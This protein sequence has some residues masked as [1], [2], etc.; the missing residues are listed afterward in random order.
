MHRP[1]SSDSFF[2]NT[3]YL[4]NLFQQYQKNPES[5]DSSWNM[6]FKGVEFAS[7]KSAGLP[8][9]ARSENLSFYKLV[10]DM[11]TQ[12]CFHAHLDPLTHTKTQASFTSESFL[13]PYKLTPTHLTNKLHPHLVEILG[14]GRL[15]AN[16]GA[17]GKPNVQAFTWKDALKALE[18]SYGGALS[19][20]AQACSPEKRDWLY[21]EFE[22]IGG[23]CELSIASEQKKQLFSSLVEAE[24]LEAFLHSRFVGTKRFSIEG[25][26]ALI[27]ML[28]YLGSMGTK[29]GVKE[30]VMGMAHRGRLNVLSNF[31]KQDMASF[32]TEL[33]AGSPVFSLLD[34]EGDLKYHNGYSSVRDFAG[35]QLKMFLAYNPSHLESVNAVVQ[36]MTRAR[37]QS[38]PGDKKSVL[39]L[40]CH[41]DAA[42]SG[43]GVVSEA[44]QLSKLEGYAVGGLLHVVLNN[45]IGFTTEPKDAR[46]SAF[47]SDMGKVIGAPSLLVNADNI[48]ACLSAMDIAFRYRQHFGEDVIIDLIGYRRYGHNEGDEPSFTQARMY[49]QIKKHKRVLTQ[50]EEELIDQSILKE[51]ERQSLMDQKM[52]ELQKHLDR[53]RDLISQS[54][55][56]PSSQKKLKE[57]PHEAI[58]KTKGALWPSTVWDS[59]P[60]VQKKVDTCP[61]DRDFNRV[62]DC[63]TQVPSLQ[64]HPKVKKLISMRERMS[65]KDRIDWATAELLAYGTLVLENHRVR[66]SGQDTK[67]GTFS[68]RHS[69]YWDTENSKEYS[70][71]LE[72]SVQQKKGHFEVTNS[73]LSEMAAMAFE[74]GF[75]VMNPNSLVL[76]EAQFGD[77]VNSAQVIIDQYLSSGEQKWMQNSALTLLL[78]H[79]FEGQGP[80]HSSARLERFLALCA[81]NNFRVCNPTTPANLFHLLRRQVKDPIKKP[82]IVMTP[83]SLLRHPDVWSKK[84]DFNR[85]GFKEIMHCSY[86]GTK[87]KEVRSLLLCSG[88]VYYDL[89]EKLKE[90]SF[91]SHKD[92]VSLLRV[93]QFYPFPKDALLSYLS[94][95]PLLEQVIWV[96]EEPA[97][98]GGASYI[99]PLLKELLKSQDGRPARFHVVSPGAKASPATGSKARHHKEQEKLIDSLFTHLKTLGS[100]NNK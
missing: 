37:Q 31:F 21:Q 91:L 52:G 56:G 63:L 58:K 51:G 81:Q 7:Q 73:P 70:P 26:D 47:S 49:E 64:L 50:F 1:R 16:G 18:K 57:T 72:L 2:L 60:S 9:L 87:A 36:G 5:L 34:I 28:F 12:A 67:R 92:Q 89:V 98:M 97:N 25:V 54:G 78:P 11:R 85:S 41:G 77:F 3:S 59:S 95:S 99:A 46:S 83:K 76:W 96:Q 100:F 88:K 62:L 65:K 42:F 22:K 33:S 90:A 48:M 15:F 6:F 71:L 8:G 24:A 93:E 17:E 61:K 29:Q 75:S 43:Q 53:A 27:P 80:E 32:F 44:L 20:Q 38:T 4:E 23:G 35:A 79:G 14:L 84:K 69:C 82:L 55:K 30:L 68:H 94:G 40:L 45:Q 66:L 39:P 13:K 86:F 10:L 19:L 74:Y